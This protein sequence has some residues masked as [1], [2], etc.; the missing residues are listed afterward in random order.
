[1]GNN[2]WENLCILELRMEKN[3]SNL[4]VVNDKSCNTITYI[5]IKVI[6]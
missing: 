2:G 1:M 3:L 5:N 6:E 4:T